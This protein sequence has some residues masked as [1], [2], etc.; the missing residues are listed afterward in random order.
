MILFYLEKNFNLD[1][2]VQMRK[3]IIFILCKNMMRKQDGI[4]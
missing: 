1:K 3:N 2:Y 4:K